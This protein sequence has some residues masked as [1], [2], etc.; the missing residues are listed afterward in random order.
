M[1]GPQL[2]KRAIERFELDL[3]GDVVLTEA[4]TGAFVCTPL[5]AALAGAERVI[6]L[7][8]DSRFGPF[9]EVREGLASLA[10]RLGVADRLEIRKGRPREAYAAADLVTNLGFVRPLDAETVGALRPGTVIALMWEPWELRPEELDVPACRERG[11][12][13]IG[14]NEREPRLRTFEAVAQSVAKLLLDHGIGLSEAR[15]LVLGRGVFPDATLPALRAAGARAEAYA[16]EGAPPSGAYDAIVC[17]EHHDW[18]TP[19]VGAGGWI[20]SDT[21]VATELLLHVCGRLDP[22]AVSGRGWRLVPA[23]PAPPGRMSFTTAVLGPEPVVDL[24]TAGLRVASAYRRGET[25][26]LEQLALPVWPERFEERL[27]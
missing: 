24:H 20:D 27:A 11:I 15:V 1:D 13:V 21:E 7:G 12:A 3:R 8:A 17:L 19:L 9:A 18:E 14:T 26:V 6:A 10:S 4:A 16:G 2:W 22:D 23:E 5:V 25:A